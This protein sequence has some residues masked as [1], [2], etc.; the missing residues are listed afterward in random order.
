M[1][2]TEE[3]L[4]PGGNGAPLE[5]AR[6]NVGAFKKLT[7]L[8]GHDKA[9]V[10]EPF[11]SIVLEPGDL[12]ALVGP[13]GAGKSRLL[14]DIEWIA[15]G[16]TPSGRR[17]QV[18]GIATDGGGRYRA[19]AQMVAQLSQ[20]MTFM[21]DLLVGEFLELHI[22]SRGLTPSPSLVGQVL[23]AANELAGESFA[24]E[25]S[26][27]RLSGGQSRALMIA[28]TALIC[29]SPI[30]L[31]DEIENA[32][33]DRRRA[34]ALLLSQE[35]L[36]I[37]ATHDPLLALQAERRLVIRN[38]GITAVLTRQ[39]SEAVLLAE[40]EGMDRRIQSVRNSLRRGEPLS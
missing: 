18:E 31:V 11:D 16:D 20:T 12:V 15:R 26:L 17:I 5:A 6:V 19:G 8:P 39:A 23:S 3:S 1:I 25:T 27:S 24:Q 32:G 38:G 30:V 10:P 29:H 22:K 7:I 13:T 37:M 40:L 14:A 4:V 35:K 28:D 36:V 2:P 34:L 21:V 9:G 33:I